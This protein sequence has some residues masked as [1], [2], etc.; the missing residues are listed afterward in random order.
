MSQ[1]CQT[2]LFFLFLT[3]FS[4][5]EVFYVDKVKGRNFNHQEQMLGRPRDWTRHLLLVGRK[6]YRWATGTTY[7][8]ILEDTGECVFDMLLK[9]FVILTLQNC[10]YEINLFKTM[11]LSLQTF[12]CVK[13]EIVMLNSSIRVWEFGIFKCDFIFLIMKA[14]NFKPNCEMQMIRQRKLTIKC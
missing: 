11:I 1:F 13:D 14:K 6:Q 8:F 12:I 9:K 4:T 3:D 2:F 10:K 5:L 7:N